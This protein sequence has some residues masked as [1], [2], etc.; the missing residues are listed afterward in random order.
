[1]NVGFCCPIKK[2]VSGLPAVCIIVCVSVFVFLQVR[3]C[4]RLCVCASGGAIASGT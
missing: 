1:M 3:V 4:G 2:R